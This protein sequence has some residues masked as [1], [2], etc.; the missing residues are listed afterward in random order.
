M[1]KFSFDSLFKW[2]VATAKQLNDL[3]DRVRSWT[4]S[5]LS[6]D[7]LRPVSVDT[8]HYSE[9]LTW[10]LSNYTSRLDN[11]VVGD[12]LTEVSFSPSLGISSIVAIGFVWPRRNDGNMTPADSGDNIEI[13]LYDGNISAYVPDGNGTKVE[14]NWNTM[15]GCDADQNPPF[16]GVGS[17]RHCYGGGQCI[18]SCFAGSGSSWI[19]AGVDVDK[20]GV[21]GGGDTDR[22]GQAMIFVLVEDNG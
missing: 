6:V 5:S 15:L 11:V 21:M 4:V 8:R 22:H 17:L 18:V 9:P 13:A 7:S 12:A 16:I 2:S 10:T 1:S 3:F 20:I 14:D 19:P